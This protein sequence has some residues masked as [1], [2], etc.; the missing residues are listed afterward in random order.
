[1]S[2]QSESQEYIQFE[3]RK[4]KRKTKQIERVVTDL[5]PP[6][7]KTLQCTVCGAMGICLME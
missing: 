6:H 2:P 1:M 5:L 3:C 7:V 4:C